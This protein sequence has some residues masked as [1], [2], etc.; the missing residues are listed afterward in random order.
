MV[1]ARGQGRLQLRTPGRGE[2]STS[3]LLPAV[4]VPA[5][6][7]DPWRWPRSQEGARPGSLGTEQV[8]GPRPSPREAQAG[9]ASKLPSS[10]F[11]EASPA[12]SGDGA[13]GGGSGT[14]HPGFAQ[15]WWP[16][17]PGE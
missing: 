7:Q 15:P 11:I 4:L 3:G 16:Q 2:A 5:P 13:R 9:K 17:D 10:N 6:V 1:R 8:A 14:P 12:G